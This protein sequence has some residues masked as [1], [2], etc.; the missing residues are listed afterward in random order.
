MSDNDALLKNETHRIIGCAM[1]VSNVLGHGFHEKPYENALI[2]EFGLQ[3]I[4][5]VQQPSF[6]LS[7]KNVRV[8]EYIPDLICFDAVVVDTKTIERISDHEV[9][10]MLNYLRITGMRVGL[11]LNFKHAKLEFKRVV[12]SPS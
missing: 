12:L 9:G 11:L 10:K 6:P 8:G 2:V 4:P 7:Y 5:V 3:H 1:E